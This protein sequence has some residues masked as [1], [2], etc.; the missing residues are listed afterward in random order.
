MRRL[1]GRAL[2]SAPCTLDY[3]R[4][5][6][7]TPDIRAEFAIEDR[8]GDRA[9][10]KN[11]VVAEADEWGRVPPHYAAMARSNGEVRQHLKQ[12]EDPNPRDHE[13]WTLLLFAARSARHDVLGSYSMQVPESMR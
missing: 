11:E 13:G 4:D 2:G 6:T 3:Q 9:I 7:S 10:N 12:T 8:H 5:V 1:A